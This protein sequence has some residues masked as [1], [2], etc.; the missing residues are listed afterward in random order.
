MQNKS[1]LLIL[2]EQEQIVPLYIP[3]TFKTAFGRIENEDDGNPGAS[4]IFFNQG[5]YKGSYGFANHRREDSP[6]VLMP[7]KGL[8]INTVNGGK[9]VVFDGGEEIFLDDSE[10]IDG[11]ELQVVDLLNYESV[12]SYERLM[13]RIDKIT[14]EVVRLLTYVDWQDFLNLS[15]DADGY[16]KCPDDE[17]SQPSECEGKSSKV[18]FNFQFLPKPISQYKFIHS[19]H[20]S[21]LVLKDYFYVKDI[22][23]RFY[24][25]THCV[26]L[27]DASNTI[28]KDCVF[29]HNYRNIALDLKS[30]H[31]IIEN[32]LFFD[33]RFRY[34]WD[35]NKATH[36]FERAAIL[37]M[38]VKE[39]NGE[40]YIP[41]RGLVVKGNTF[42]GFFDGIQARPGIDF[43]DYAPFDHTQEIDIY[44]NVFY[45]IA[46]DCIDFDGY[47]ANCRVFNNIAY[48]VHTFISAAPGIFA[49]LYVINNLIYGLG[50]GTNDNHSGTGLKLNN[51]EKPS[52]GKIFFFH[53]TINVHRTDDV[54]HAV[55]IS[56]PNGIDFCLLQN[57]VL[58]G[59]H[60]SVYLI[61]S[62]EDP[63][64]TVQTD[65][66]LLYSTLYLIKHVANGETNR[67]ETLEE[68]FAGSGNGE[69]SIQ[70]SETSIFQSNSFLLKE[71]EDFSK[72][73][74][75]ISGI[76]DK[77]ES[78]DFGIYEN[79]KIPPKRSYYYTEE[80]LPIEE[81]KASAF[82]NATLFI[83]LAAMF[84]F[85]F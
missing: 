69:H 41:S 2:K 36:T 81:N 35:A 53:N 14:G 85:F 3:C 28:I 8:G 23:F 9:S 31:N 15:Y 39:V 55:R 66:N 57:N 63:K 40:L 52:V 21:A 49:L 44:D 54:S 34:S 75:R 48:D 58:I 59:D 83:Y 1:C 74:N 11:N 38:S 67:Y 70:V 37:S 77:F 56:N 72:K 4:I 61:T 51:S 80:I 46:D 82:F 79:L 62:T 18:F 76:N 43:D 5:I 50:R 19:S 25:L 42:H 64:S 45:N 60:Y 68:Y 10:T 30:E 33:T 16:F 73:G 20:S 13:A 27:N 78:V 6:V 12:N 32:N 17:S 84:F 47:A 22:E 71:N 24:G 7:R 65:Y 29:H 26:F